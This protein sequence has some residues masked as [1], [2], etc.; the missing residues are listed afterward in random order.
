MR[1]A[2]RPQKRSVRRAKELRKSAVT[3]RALQAQ[4]RVSGLP[5]PTHLPCRRKKARKASPA[6]ESCSEFSM[7]DALSS[8]SEVR[9]KVKKYDISAQD[10]GALSQHWFDH[11]YYKKLYLEEVRK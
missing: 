1:K 4:E 11:E 6:S 9:A 2:L 3:F 10:P 8:D 7:C 5:F